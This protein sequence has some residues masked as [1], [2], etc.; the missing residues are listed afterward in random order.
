MGWE[1]RGGKTY[2]YQK[3]RD[4]NRAYSEYYGSGEMAELHAQF[5]RVQQTERKL[6]AEKQRHIK[7]E[8]EQA[9]DEIDELFSLN[10]ILVDALFL[11]NGYHEHSRQWRKK[12]KQK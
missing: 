7:R 1:K 10:A 2:F 8:I 3:K 12:R 11:V 6:R 4:G 9:D 5:E